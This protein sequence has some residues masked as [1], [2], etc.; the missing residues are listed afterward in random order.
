[1][2]AGWR[3]VRK[4]GVVVTADWQIGDG[5]VASWQRVALSIAP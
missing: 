4:T 5:S 2:A 3:I 1:M